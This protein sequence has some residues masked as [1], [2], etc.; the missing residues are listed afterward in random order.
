MLIACTTIFSG[1][2][3]AQERPSS[4]LESLSLH[5]PAAD[6]IR[7]LYGHLPKQ[8]GVTVSPLLGRSRRG[9]FLLGASADG[10]PFILLRYFIPRLPKLAFRSAYSKEAPNI[11]KP[12]SDDVFELTDP[13]LFISDP[14]QADTIEILVFWTDASGMPPPEPRDW[15][16]IG[17]DS[18]PKGARFPR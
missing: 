14:A 3:T 1:A 9:Q 17:R 13:R 8:P 2:T 7:S 15:I 11:M 5:S 18:F 6:A 10:S 4:K 12:T 16:R